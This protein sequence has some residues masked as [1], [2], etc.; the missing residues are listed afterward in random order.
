MTAARPTARQ[1][2]RKVIAFMNYTGV[3][4][5]ICQKPFQ[6]GDDIVVCPD[7]GAPY[8]RS[9]FKEAG[10][11]VMTD[12]HQTGAEWVN[13]NASRPE[14]ERSQPSIICPVCGLANPGDQ[15]VCSRCGTPLPQ[16][17]SQN[18]GQTVVP[19]VD[20][21][22]PFANL[23]ENGS[24]HTMGDMFGAIHENDLI[25]DISARDYIYYTQGNYFYF[26]RVFKI[27]G[28]QVKS[29]VFNWAAFFFNFMY[30]FYRKMYKKGFLL[31]GVF[32]LT[33]IPSV[34]LSYHMMQQAVVNPALLTTL[35]F[36]LS[37]LEG[38]TLAAN[39][40]FYVRLGFRI[41]GGLTANRTYYQQASQQIRQ[42]R[43]ESGSLPQEDY[44]ALLSQAGGVSMKAVLFVFLGLVAL[45]FATSFAISALLLY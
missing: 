8:H 5:P 30:F 17:S 25:G 15:T 39:L 26:L 3:T 41:Y 44:T 23:E 33:N 40:M 29:R 34:L 1:L 7:C 10:H 16:R 21:P 20:L 24:D 38:L 2:L 22:G 13:P 18:P 36:D 37:G 32:L 6:Q 9:C 31:L 45:L 19:G 43:A 4:C 35:A 27:F 14:S 12:L 42:I 11:C 28:Q